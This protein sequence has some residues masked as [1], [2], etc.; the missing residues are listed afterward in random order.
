MR[1]AEEVQAAR[2]A[3]AVGEP[4]EEYQRI[5]LRLEDGRIV[6]DREKIAAQAIERL[7]FPGNV[8]GRAR[9]ADRFAR[10]RDTARGLALVQRLGDLVQQPH[11]FVHGQRFVQAF[12]ER[13][14]AV[15]RHRRRAESTP[16]TSFTWRRTL[17]MASAE[18]TCSVKRMNAWDPRESVLT[19]VTLMRS[20]A[21][22]SEMSRS[23]P[24]RSSATTSRSAEKGASPLVL[25]QSA[26]IMRS[27]CDASR[28]VMFGQSWRCTLTPRVPVMEPTIGSRGTGLHHFA[29]IVAM[30]FTPSTSTPE[31]DFDGAGATMGTSGVG[32]GA[33]SPR[34]AI[35][36]WRP[37]ISPRP[38]AAKNSSSL[39]WP[40]A[41]A[42]LSWDSPT[43]PMRCSSLSSAARPAAT[44]FSKSSCRNHWR[45]FASARELAR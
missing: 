39:G 12:L 29:T 43:A 31:E 41:T 32:V 21:I 2:R 13:S 1:D 4:A 28:P 40:V 14:Q 44:S 23:N 38:S 7:R 8:A 45:T 6:R 37:V 36:I 15:D 22:A 20:R 33:V 10:K 11:A 30:L 26:G 5:V 3:V 25:P 34:T 35:S 16:G 42:I 19:A 24:C 9:E 27:R 18:P 17:M